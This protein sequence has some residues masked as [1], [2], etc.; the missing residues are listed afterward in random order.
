M[1]SSHRLNRNIS[2]C[3]VI[4]IRSKRFSKSNSKRNSSFGAPCHLPEGPLALGV[5]PGE[6]GQ[7]ALVVDLVATVGLLGVQQVRLRVDP[8]AVLDAQ[9]AGPGATGFV[10]GGHIEDRIEE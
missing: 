3:N 1:G 6:A 9:R 8:L 5:P 2:H 4:P 10:E 7:C